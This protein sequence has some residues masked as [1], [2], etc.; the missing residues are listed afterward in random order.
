MSGRLALRLVGKSSLA[1]EAVS[2]AA[3]MAH[4]R[5]RGELDGCIVVP[6][7]AHQ[8]VFGDTRGDT[9]VRRCDVILVRTTART[10]RMECVEV[11]SRRAAALPAALVDDIVD[12][13]DATVTMLH[14]TFFR[15]D[16]PRIDAELQ[17]ARLGGIL[18]H[19][20]DRALAMGL[21]DDRRRGEVER[22]IE[23]V[24]DGALVP[25]IDRRGYVGEPRRQGR[26]P[27]RAPRGADRRP[28]G[29]RSGGGRVLLPADRGRPTARLGVGVDR[30]RAHRGHHGAACAARSHSA[31]TRTP[32]T[33]FAKAASRRTDGR[34][35]EAGLHRTN[36]LSRGRS[37]RRRR[38]RPS[39]WRR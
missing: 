30:R 36:P 35:G 26:F 27:G 12:Q 3:L 18:R 33:A 10:M 39:S 15:A 22:M 37:S 23:K 2:L 31:S 7:D 1:T 9:G 20:A 21:L 38:S 14:D 32:P 6:V 8:E 24:E 28:D 4:L 17:R 29:G 13:L 34:P 25:E 11:K 16:P 5:R 19:H